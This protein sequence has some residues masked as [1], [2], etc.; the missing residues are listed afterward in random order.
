MATT[1][2]KSVD[3]ST[4]SGWA[5]VDDGEHTLTIKAKA[6]GY[7]DSVASEGV[8]FTK[9]ASGYMVTIR[10]LDGDGY[11]VYDGKTISGEPVYVSAWST[12][13]V[14]CTSGYLL[15]TA[16]D[17]IG[18][19]SDYSVYEGDITIEDISVE[20]GGYD[21]KLVTVNSDGAITMSFDTD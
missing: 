12:V 7:A 1:T 9:G 21:D 4:L 6:S 20:G 8:L 10:N 15:I 19:W 11:Y 18:V 16:G 2:Q 14:L 17:L 13:D 3:L 5:N